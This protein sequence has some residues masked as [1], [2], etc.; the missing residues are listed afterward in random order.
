MEA[1]C[2]RHKVYYQTREQA[3]FYSPVNVT[4]FS[5]ITYNR[6][7]IDT[8]PSYCAS[9]SIV[10][11]LSTKLDWDFVGDAV[12][13]YTMFLEDDRSEVWFGSF[14]GSMPSK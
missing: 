9:S 1:T 12:G 2:T 13:T 11:A 5:T 4:P 3:G 8:F 14:H 7:Q 6:D 10:F